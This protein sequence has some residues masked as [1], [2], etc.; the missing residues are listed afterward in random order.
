M[1][2]PVR[3]E[4]PAKTKTYLS[5]GLW[6]MEK[7]MTEEEAKN[8]MI[9]MFKLN[10]SVDMICEKYEEFKEKEMV[11]KLVVIH[12]SL[13]PKPKKTNK[14]ESPGDIV[15]ELVSLAT[16]VAT[17]SVATTSESITNL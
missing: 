14:V 13:K 9:E 17:T 1:N 12:K 2:T 6:I 4:I 8:K 5:F 11:E 3:K 15:N 10:E 7:L 16:S